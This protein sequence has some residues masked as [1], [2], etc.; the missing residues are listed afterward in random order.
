MCVAQGYLRVP[1]WAGRL[2]FPS[3]CEPCEY[4]SGVVYPLPCHRLP[5]PSSR[6]PVTY[7]CWSATTCWHRWLSFPQQGIGQ[8][9]GQKAEICRLLWARSR[10]QGGPGGGKQRKEAGCACGGML[11]SGKW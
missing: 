6:P 11:L 7:F 1:A 4:G 9:E 3:R 8:S 5:F 2:Q 10:L